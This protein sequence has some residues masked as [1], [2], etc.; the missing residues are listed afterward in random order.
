MRDCNHPLAASAPTRESISPPKPGSP[1]FARQFK[2][3]VRNI[4]R[5]NPLFPRF[6]A[7]VL[8]DRAPNSNA[9]KILRNNYPKI[10]EKVNMAVARQQQSQTTRTCTHIKVTGVRCGS[11]SLRGEQFCYFHQRMYRGVRTPPQAR[12]RTLSLRSQS[13]STLRDPK[14]GCSSAR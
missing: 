8:I 5:A 12:A 2:S 4:L 7:D 10:L 1:H 13:S 3:Y 11:P 6:Y 9:S 14:R